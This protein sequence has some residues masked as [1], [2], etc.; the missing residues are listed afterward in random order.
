MCNVAPFLEKSPVCVSS[1]LSSEGKDDTA[2]RVRESTLVPVD[3]LRPERF[4]IY[5]FKR[6]STLVGVDVLRPARF[7]MNIFFDFFL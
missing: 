5:F 6:E 2:G 3:V 7:F 1:S 4:F